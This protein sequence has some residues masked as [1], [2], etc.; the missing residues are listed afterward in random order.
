MN[1]ITEYLNPE[2]FDIDTSDI[3][4]FERLYFLHI[5]KNIDLSI[6]IISEIQSLII[7]NREPSY[8]VSFYDNGDENAKRKYSR[9]RNSYVE[10][11]S[12]PEK[13][14][15]LEF[16]FHNNACYEYYANVKITKSN[17]SL[18]LFHFFFTLK[19][20]QYAFALIHT[21]DFLDHQLESNFRRDRE[22]YIEFLSLLLRQ[23]SGLFIDKLIETINDYLNKLRKKAPADLVEA[24]SFLLVG[25]R[26]YRKEYFIKNANEFADAFIGL[27]DNE[28]IDPDTKLDQFKRIFTQSTIQPDRR[29]IWIGRNVELKWF[30]QILSDDQSKIVPPIVGRWKTTL[31]C[32]ANKNGE[33]FEEE[34]VISKASGK[35]DERKDILK[36]LLEKL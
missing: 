9:D 1:I 4:V 33:D 20:R 2:C 26:D 5:E 28:F 23:Y 21:P 10:N 17:I 3:W 27:K 13:I 8:D 19:L 30:V 25:Y 12:S 24:K 22:S 6:R 34:T 32:F 36:N 16:F 11:L 7:K 31:Y 29:I 15:D 18:N 14:F 35:P